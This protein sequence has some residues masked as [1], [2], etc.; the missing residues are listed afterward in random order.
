MLKQ[1]APIILVA[2]S[3]SVLADDKVDWNGIYSS[4]MIGS[5]FGNS[6][7]KD[8]SVSY[9]LANGQVDGNAVYPIRNDKSSF[10]GINGTV[11]IG[12]NKQVSDFLI[13]VE[14]GAIWQDGKA[15]QPLNGARDSDGF[16]TAHSRIQI[17][18]YQT[19][20]LR[21]GKL[22][23]NKTL[24]Y[25]TGGAAIGQIKGKLSHLNDGGGWTYIPYDSLSNSKTDLGYAVGFGVEHKLNEKISLRAHYEYVDFGNV[26]LSYL[27]PYFSGQDATSIKPSNSINFSNLSA[28]ISYNF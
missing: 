5:T 6:Q 15:N 20:S 4:A 16:P 11:K 12:Y 1:I 28:G 26:N 9:L 23:N 14:L 18:T 24:A 27:Q 3:S 21:L 2:L 25:I 17:D 19:F 8:G 13:G 10:N 22:F 7:S